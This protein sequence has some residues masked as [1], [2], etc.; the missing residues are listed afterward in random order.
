MLCFGSM[1]GFRVNLLLVVLMGNLLLVSVRAWEQI[2]DN[3][4][5]S[6]YETGEWR[7][8]QHIKLPGNVLVKSFLVH[9]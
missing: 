1:A 7:D 3:K 2:D 5:H 4:L 8:P 6:F 9:W